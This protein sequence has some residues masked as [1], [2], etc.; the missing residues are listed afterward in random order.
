MLNLAF[1]RGTRDEV[2]EW[3]MLMQPPAMSAGSITLAGP[4]PIVPPEQHQA[5]TP[6]QLPSHNSSPRLHSSRGICQQ[7]AGNPW[8]RS[9]PP[10]LAP[11]LLF[12]PNSTNISQ[13]S[14]PFICSTQAALGCVGRCSEVWWEP[15]AL[16]GV[17]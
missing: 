12:H 11:E 2:T 10:H 9:S 5:V 14:C 1:H 16:Q 7:M 3:W 6:P 15:A 4:A 13:L 17:G 8:Q